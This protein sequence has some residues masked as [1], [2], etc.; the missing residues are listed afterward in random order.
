MLV[1]LY[2]SVTDRASTIYPIIYAVA[3]P[4]VVRGRLDRKRSEQHHLIIQGSNE[5][6]KQK[7]KVKNDKKTASK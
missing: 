7:N 1:L 5:S 2:I 4:V 3:N 6:I